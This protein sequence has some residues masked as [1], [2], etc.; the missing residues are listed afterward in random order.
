YLGVNPPV[1]CVPEWSC[2]P[3]APDLRQPPGRIRKVSAS[4]GAVT[5]VTTARG[6]SPGLSPDGTTLM[7]LDSGTARR[8]VVANADG[9]RRDT[10]VLAPNEAPVGWLNGSSLLLASSGNLR[11][12]R[13]MSLADGQSRIVADSAD[14]FMDPSWSPDGK[15]MSVVV[16]G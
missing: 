13:A 6:V 2:L 14:M 12:L 10:L 8:W 3:L 1:A 4:G 7:Y 11:R 15:R 9:T 5:D 16:R